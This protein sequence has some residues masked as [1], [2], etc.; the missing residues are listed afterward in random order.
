MTEQRRSPGEIC[1]L[2][3]WNQVVYE[4]KRQE[5]PQLT[6]MAWL[7]NLTFFTDFTLHFNALNKQLQ[8]VGKTAERVLCD[9]KIFERKL[10]VFEKDVESG[11]LNYFPNLKVH[12]ENSPAF[13]DNTTSHQEIYV[14]FS[15]F[16]AAATVNFSKRFL[17]FRKL[18][19]TYPA[20]WY[21]SN[22]SKIWRTW[23]FPQTLVG[24]RK[25]WYEAMEFQ[26]NYLEKQTLRSAWST[27]EDRKD[28]MW[29][30][31]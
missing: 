28:D 19:T 23:S 29:Q 21:F 11:Q 9:I 26:E 25:S 2:L 16:V 15:S 14:K 13:A 7:A 30:H 3:R 22:S 4:W 10:Q 12:M 6:D 20:F 17:Q 8:G 5:Y 31:T 24:F 1:R 27:F 18:E